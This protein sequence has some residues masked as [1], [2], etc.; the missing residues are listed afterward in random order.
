MF[1]CNTMTTYSANP[2]SRCGKERI[3]GKT[4]K[5][6]IENYFGTSYITHT[7]TVCPDKACQKIV[8]EKMDQAR[9][10]TKEL[11]DLKAEKNAERLARGKTAKLALKRA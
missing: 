4:W 6:K 3:E 7:E 11:N 1:S 5:E 8:E 10:K 9:Q 2:C